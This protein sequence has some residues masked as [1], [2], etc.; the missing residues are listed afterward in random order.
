M[1]I[2]PTTLFL[3][4][5]LIAQIIGARDRIWYEIKPW[6]KWWKIVLAIGF[7]IFVTLVLVWACGLE[8]LLLHLLSIK[9]PIGFIHQ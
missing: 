2:R 7:G 5:V 1:R 3:I 4:S 8:Y 9:Y 6:P